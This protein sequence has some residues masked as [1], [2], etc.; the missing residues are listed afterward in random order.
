MCTHTQKKM[1]AFCLFYIFRNMFFNIFLH[2]FSSSRLWTWGEK[3]FLTCWALQCRLQSW[4]R[5]TKKNICSHRITIQTSLQFLSTVGLK[6]I[7]FER[8]DSHFLRAKSILVCLWTK[9][10]DFHHLQTRGEVW[11]QN[12][13]SSWAAWGVWLATQEREGVL[14]SKC[15]TAKEEI[16]EENWVSKN[17]E[18]SFTFWHC[19]LNDSQE[20]QANSWQPG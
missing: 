19:L 8:V 9:N 17:F 15:R 14:L 11:R 13:G 7:T 10:W 6:S 12:L 16:Q 2:I 20:V 3:R 5:Q 1:Y 4:V 18:A